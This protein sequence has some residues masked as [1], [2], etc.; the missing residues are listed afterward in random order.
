MPGVENGFVANTTSVLYGGVVQYKCFK[1]F[2][3]EGDAEITCLANGSWTQKPSC[4]GEY[5]NRVVEGEYSN[6]VVEG[7]YSNREVEGEYSNRVVEG[8]YSNRVIEG[9]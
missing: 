1:G 7:E 4:K 8:E 5:S 2:T 6:R 9:E 3:L